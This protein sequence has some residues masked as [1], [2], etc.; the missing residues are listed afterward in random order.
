MVT[1]ASGSTSY[2]LQTDFTDRFDVRTASQLLSDTEEALT[3]DEVEGSERLLTLLKEASGEV[4]ANALAGNRYRIAE[5]INDLDE[6]TGN[7]LEFL[8][9]LICTLAASKLYKRRPDL[10][11][12]I[13]PDVEAAR[14]LLE[15]LRNGVLIFGTVEHAQTGRISHEIQ[16]VAHEVDRRGFSTLTERWLGTRGWR[17]SGREGV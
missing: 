17:R 1:A 8:K 6:L 7:S 5:G 2:A 9:G 3:Q 11:Q 12:K 16:S 13:A 10:L 15:Q 4:E 14:E